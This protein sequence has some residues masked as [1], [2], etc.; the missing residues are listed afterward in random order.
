MKFKSFYA[1]AL[2]ATAL[3]TTSFALTSCEDDEEPNRPVAPVAKTA[4]ATGVYTVSHSI[5]V[6][7]FG[8]TMHM[9]TMPNQQIE[10]KALT[11]STVSLRVAG[12]ELDLSQA[13]G[14]PYAFVAARE[15]TLPS[16]KATVASDGTLTINDKL[17]SN[18]TMQMVAAGAVRANTPYTDYANAATS[19]E[20]TIKDG[21]IN[22]KLSVKPGRMPFPL[23]Y[24]LVG[25][26]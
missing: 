10:V 18:Q 25:K 23:D 11:D 13:Q 14:A 1:A 21:N 3:F 9:G 6:N 19:V 15:F 12:Y 7:A 2:V 26:R 4:S 20:G 8:R 16:V 24:T 22:L 5:D 17:T